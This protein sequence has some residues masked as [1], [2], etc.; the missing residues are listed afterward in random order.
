MF[1]ILWGR[2]PRYSEVGANT[3]S[4]ET[5]GRNAQYNNL[6]RVGPVWGIAP[7]KG[8]TV[9]VTYNALYAP[10]EVPTRATNTALFSGTNQFRGHYFQTSVR[11]AFTKQLS[12][13]FLGEAYFQGNFYTHRETM[14]FVRTE[15]M[16]TF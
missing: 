4:I 6:I 15:L 5:G 12:A 3:F 2:Y 16:F 8:M 14:T 10:E 1:D 9:G 7:I 13:W 11:Y